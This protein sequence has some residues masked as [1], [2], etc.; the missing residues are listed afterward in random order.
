MPDESS[1]TV[2][3]PSSSAPSQWAFA[4]RVVAMCYSS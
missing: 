1:D 4:V 2:P 3:E